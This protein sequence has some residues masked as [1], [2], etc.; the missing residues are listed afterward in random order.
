MFEAR[1]CHIGFNIVVVGAGAVEIVDRD[2][3][4]HQCGVLRASA[5]GCP[6]W[7]TDDGYTC[8]RYVVLLDVQQVQ[9]CAGLSVETKADRR[10]DAKTLVA[11]VIATGDAAILPHGIETESGVGNGVNCLINVD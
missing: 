9:P 5:L 1:R 3:I 4:V 2:R 11:D 7:Y 8:V 10:R 6:A